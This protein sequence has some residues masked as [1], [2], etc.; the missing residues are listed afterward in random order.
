[1]T[2]DLDELSPVKRA[3]AEIRDLRSRLAAAELSAHEPIAVVGMGMR[4]PGG[5]H[6]ADS[7][8]QLLSE[9]IDAIREV[10]AERWSADA[11]YDTDPET[12]GR[13]N[14]RW[15]GFLDDVDQF[16]HAFFGISP[17]EAESL[18]PQQR[19]LLEVTWE[20]LEH[21]SIPAERLFA[22]RA[23]VFLGIANSDYMRM[24]LAD[25]DLIDT[26]TTT[27]NALSIAA[28]RLAYVLG[29]TGP[30]ISVDTACSSSLVAVHLAI[31][32]LRNRECD[33]ALAGGVNLILA[34]ELTIN[35]SMA[36]MM[37]SDGR[38]KTFDAA[39]DGYVRSEGCGMVVLKRLSDA[40]SAGDNVLAIIRGSAVN[41]DGRSGGL[42]APNG[43][44]QEHVI[45]D[46]LEAAQ[47]DAAQVGYVEA[48]GTGTLLGD[49]IE[50]GAIGAALCAGRDESRPLLVGSVKTNIGHT[51]SAAGIAGLIKVVLMLRHRAVPAHLHLSELNPHIAGYALP[52][53]VPTAMTDWPSDELRVAGV[54]SFGL[55]GTNAHIV[56]EE[57]PTA[58]LVAATQT[59]ADDP[60]PILTISAR[61]DDALDALARRYVL[62]LRSAESEFVGVAR[63]SN[64]GRSHLSHRLA[65]VAH[66]TAEAIEQLE[67]RASGGHPGDGA[68]SFVDSRSVGGSI[69]GGIAMLFTGH[70][71]HHAGAGRDLYTTESVFAAAIDQ[72][73]ALLRDEMDQSLTDVL[74]GDGR[75]LGNIAYAQPALFSLQHALTR[76]WASWGVSPSIVAGHSAGE[77]AAAVT[78]G[79]MNLEDGLRLIA[80]RGRLMASL[81]DEGAMVALFVD[82]A[83]VAPAVAR[84]A[85][86]VGI[87]AVNGPDSTVISG[88]RGAVEAVIAELGIDDDELRRLDVSIAAHSPLVDPIV[89]SLGNVVAGIRLTRPTL[90]L[91]SSSLG[92][93]V[94]RELTDVGYWR[95]HLREPV[96]FAAVVDTL[97]AAGCST[98]VEIGAHPTLLGIARRNWPDDRATWVGSLQ[99]GGDDRLQMALG[100]ATLF[101]GGADID[102]DAVHRRGDSSAVRPMRVSLP[103]Y[104]WQRSTHW[105]PRARWGERPAAAPRWP[106]AVDA[107][108]VQST[109]GPLDL[110]VDTYAERFRELSDL[111]V[112]CVANALREMELFAEPGERRRAEELLT[113]GRVATGY[114]HLAGRWLDH[115]VAAGLLGRDGEHLVS[116]AALPVTDLTARA[117]ALR[118]L[119]AGIEPLLDYVVR[120]GRRLADVAT[121]RETA[122]STLFPDGSYETVDFIYSQWA[123]PR[124]FN[125]IVRAG[126]AAIAAARPGRLRVLEVGAGTGGTSAAVLPALA[127]DRTSYTF[128]DVSDFFLARAAERFAEFP[129]VRYARFDVERS[130]DEQSFEAGSFDLVIAANV[131]HATKHLDT[132]L[133][134]V[135][136]LLAPGGVL[137]AYEGTEHPVWFDITTGLIEGWQRFDDAWRSDVPLLSP[138]QWDEALRSNGFDQ[139]EAFPGD[140]S[141]TSSLLHHVLVARAD[142]EESGAVAS[143][144]P[145]AAVTVEGATVPDATIGNVLE[146][147]ASALPEERHDVIVDAVRNTIA[148]VLRVADPS[149]LQRDQPLLDLGF[150]SLMAVELRNVLRGTFALERK[151]PATIVF[152]H[153]TINAIA[154]YL[155]GFL[156]DGARGAVPGDRIESTQRVRRQH[157]DLL[158][159]DD[160]AALSDEDVEAMLLSRLTDMER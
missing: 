160:V 58:E 90:G 13:M 21:A 136:R 107:A 51:E 127:P 153:P 123:V 137:L 159:T 54:S 22:S 88:R 96:R 125:G 73:A 106:A 121:G 129:F 147:L 41:Q 40:R 105:S 82:E 77:Y 72:C 135:R 24:L 81:P 116:T 66:D 113:G 59:S 80:A 155:D 34:P 104:P 71:S 53:E 10:P 6:D 23:G 134:N 11:L 139:V 141:P 15:G 49:P 35:F 5:V 87:A 140:D 154:T 46:A 75:L 111:A 85:I 28:G 138:A 142:G 12:P 7:Y 124:Y 103:S 114:E 18:D 38:C 20:A 9:G 117:D 39:A 1:M 64:V 79:V 144:V 149:R 74:F 43:P 100:A 65:V 60:P 130:P 148:R 146:Q 44:S 78:A 95:Q 33:L 37:A 56:L 98:F 42:T 76:L 3:I 94:D 143:H 83:T 2:P 16:D 115:L 4:F 68:S 8:W 55:S 122:L 89:G 126:A 84:H 120:C 50:I 67:S 57:A 152:D 110:H 69:A 131:L 150:D 61:G 101:A 91:V 156:D 145:D 92:R 133:A 97:R 47:V 158:D 14:T 63:S 17:R 30:A 112:L 99:R 132:A 151:L 119:F 157:V 48:H 86:D 29:T 128:T 26:Y 19:L 108:R 32:S 70:G 109:Q 52:I 27:G 102:W 62:L 31:Q 45:R 118:P 36:R 25:P 93:F